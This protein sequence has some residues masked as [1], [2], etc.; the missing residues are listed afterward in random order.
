MYFIYTYFTWCISHLYIYSIHINFW[1]QFKGYFSFPFCTFPLYSFFH[2]HHS[3]LMIRRELLQVV[4]SISFFSSF[5]LIYI[6]LFWMQS[7]EVR[8][9]ISIFNATSFHKLGEK[10]K[11]TEIEKI[12]LLFFY[13]LLV[14]HCI[15]LLH[16]KIPF[17]GRR[18]RKWKISKNSFQYRFWSLTTE[19]PS[20]LC[21]FQEFQ[22]FQQIKIVHLHIDV[23]VLFMYIPVS[24]YYKYHIKW[25]LWN[26]HPHIGSWNINL[27]P[28]LVTF[29]TNKTI[30]ASQHKVQLLFIIGWKV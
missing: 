25:Y 16:W 2:M 13:A 9:G 17:F 4:F 22:P 28:S 12:G 1:R 15:C 23:V 26:T 5:L 21:W 8:Q 20:I 19:L 29:D 30:P 10:Y 24:L 7:L 6:S 3:P 14:F 11:M 27:Q 18:V